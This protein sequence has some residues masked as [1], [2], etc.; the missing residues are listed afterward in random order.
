MFNTNTNQNTE[1][2]EQQIV[3]QK[4][5]KKLKQEEVVANL[6]AKLKKSEEDLNAYT[7][8]YK[9]KVKEKK[10]KIKEIEKDL[11]SAT[12]KLKLELLEKAKTDPSVLDKILKL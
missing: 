4:A 5:D 2:V 1:T 3:A 9:Q 8:I 11:A 10:D 6:K 7:I 12:D